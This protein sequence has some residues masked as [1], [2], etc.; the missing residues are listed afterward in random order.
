MALSS[1][2]LTLWVTWQ[3]EGG[4]AAVNEAGRMRMQ[5]WR[6]PRPWPR[7]T[8]RRRRRSW[9]Q[10]D[11]SLAL[12]RNGDPARP[13]FVPRDARTQQAFAEVQRDWLQLKALWGAAG[14]AAV[15]R[16]RA[17]RC[18]RGPHR[19]LRLGHRAPAVAP[20]GDPQ[21]GAVRDGGADHRQRHGVLLYSAYLFIFNPLARLQAGLARVEAGD[22]QARVEPGADDEFGALAPASTAWRRR[23]R[24]STRAWSRKVQ[25]KTE[26]LQAAAC[27]PGGPV[28]IG[29]LRGAGRHAGG[30]AQGIARQVRQVARADASA[31]R[32]SDEANRKYLLLASDCLPQAVIEKEQCIPTGDCLCGQPQGRPRRA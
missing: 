14:T 1:I 5:T 18:L 10:F 21:R 2:G 13:L 31:V 4:A 9:P 6:W 28:R 19:Q 32:W 7:P 3:L 16:R 12:L 29:R 25:E 20:D 24:A 30:L 15:R 26:R 17:G 22:L 8:G 27:A 11:Q 23:C